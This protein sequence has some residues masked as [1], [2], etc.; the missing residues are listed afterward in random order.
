[1]IRTVPFVRRRRLVGGIAIVT[2]MMATL[3]AGPSAVQAQTKPAG[4]SA[5]ANVDA[6][7]VEA[8]GNCELGDCELGDCE[9]GGWG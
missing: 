8:L 1:M 2:M 6:S 4:P 9:L 5:S 7:T 3:A